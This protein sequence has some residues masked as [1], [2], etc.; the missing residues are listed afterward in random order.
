MLD[1]FY[2]DRGF[3][4]LKEFLLCIRKRIFFL[5][6]PFF[7]FFIKIY[8]YKPFG[9]YQN[10][11][12]NFNLSNFLYSIPPFL[13]NFSHVPMHGKTNETL[14]IAIFIL[15]FI[16]FVIS[17]FKFNLTKKNN[18]NK[19]LIYLGI[20]FLLLSSF[21]YLI[22]GHIHSFETW[23]SRHQILMPLG[24]SFFLVGVHNLPWNFFHLGKRENQVKFASIVFLI[25]ISIAFQ[26]HFYFKAWI[27]SKKQAYQIQLISK[28]NV[29]KNSNL[30]IFYDEFGNNEYLQ[31]L[32][33]RQIETYEWNS[34]MLEAFKDHNQS[35]YGISASR[36]YYFENYFISKPSQSALDLEMASSHK[37]DISKFTLVTFKKYLNANIFECLFGDMSSCMFME[38][39]QYFF[40]Q[41]NG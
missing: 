40:E 14:I 39:K 37:Y 26:I 16:V 33:K 31:N 38:V 18:T 20:F 15:P 13:K 34:M 24:F 6:L 3:D 19:I 11:N 1:I 27:D 30:I 2:S 35:R 8:L 21:P 9:A 5:V 25:A 23:N 17:K 29:I 10:Y 4:S 7:Y 12:T 28:N 32:Y 36:A 22:L 41:K